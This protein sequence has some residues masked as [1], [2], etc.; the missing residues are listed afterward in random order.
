MKIGA[1]KI[2]ESRMGALILSAAVVGGGIFAACMAWGAEY[3]AAAYLPEYSEY[4]ASAGFV[5]ATL[6]GAI[7]IEFS[8][9]RDEI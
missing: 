6:I 7:C 8:F 5:F 9:Q 3:L 4:A 1:P 2:S